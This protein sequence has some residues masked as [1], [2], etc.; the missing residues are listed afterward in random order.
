VKATSIS[1]LVLAARTSIGLLRAEAA[2]CTSLIVGSASG[3]L[4]LTSTAKRA[5]AGINS[6]NISSCLAPRSERRS[7]TPVILPRGRLR[8]ATRPVADL[9]LSVRKTRTEA[10]QPPDFSKPP[11]KRNRGDRVARGQRGELHA[12]C[13]EHRFGA[14]QERIGSLLRKNGK[15]HVDLAVGARGKDFDRL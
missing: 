2:S 3:L 4:G 6:C 12:T 1:P 14:D 8:L 11:F 5:A 10:H 15:G 9:A 13:D 7:I